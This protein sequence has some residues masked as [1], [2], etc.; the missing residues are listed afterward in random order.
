M[1]IHG[2]YN[3][4]CFQVK[5]LRVAQFLVIVGFSKVLFLIIILNGSG[6][7]RP[8]YVIGCGCKFLRILKF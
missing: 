8:S 5:G 2:Y 7:I 4:G 3:R 6:E 1:G